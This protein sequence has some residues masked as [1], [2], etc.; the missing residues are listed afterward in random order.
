MGGLNPPKDDCL[1]AKHKKLRA[2]EKSKLKTDELQ[3]KYG[4]LYHSC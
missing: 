4:V 2:P 3:K 1:G